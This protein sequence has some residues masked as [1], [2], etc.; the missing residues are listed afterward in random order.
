[1]CGG[2]G[3][4]FGIDP[5]MFRVVLAVLAVF[6]G[7]GVVVYGLLWLLVP[8][9]GAQESAGER[10]VHG[11]A[12]SSSVVA[13]IAAVL[14]IWIFA[15]FLFGHP[16]PFGLLLLVAAAIGLVIASRHSRPDAPGMPAGVPA[17]P[18]A[19]TTPLPGTAGPAGATYASFS[20]TAATDLPAYAPPPPPPPKRE[21]SVLPGVTLSLAAIAVGALVGWSLWA[22]TALTA[23]TVAATVLIICGAGLFVGAVI[24]RGRILILPGLLAGA[25]LLSTSVVDVP[26][27]G[28]FGERRWSPAAVTELAS[29]YR[30][31]MGRGELDL[32]ALDPRGASVP[33]AASLGVGELLVHVP[34]DVDVV[35]DAQSGMGEVLL[36][37]G[38]VVDGR[39]TVVDVRVPADGI[40][41]GTLDL[42]LEVGIGRVEVRRAAS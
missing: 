37:S 20:G 3:R 40:S 12:D 23:R 17:G 22:D 14:G 32:T 26:P 42:D 34:R 7:T 9:E 2:L 31:G 28:G 39:D 25:V 10:L 19:A 15:G 18:L 35:V 29:P 33:V 13:V 11:R 36:P 41:R 24:G 8:E 27:R 16:R 5:L 38:R 21:R 6:G 1:V 4:Y 30:L